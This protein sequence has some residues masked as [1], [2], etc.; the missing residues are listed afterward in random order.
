MLIGKYKSIDRIS[1]KSYIISLTVSNEK[2]EIIIPIKIN[3]TMTLK[4]IDIC[5][6]NDIFGVK[7]YISFAQLKP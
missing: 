2:N 5:K 3:K 4:I 7:G 6:T 1:K